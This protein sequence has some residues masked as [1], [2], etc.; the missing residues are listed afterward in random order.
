MSDGLDQVYVLGTSVQ[1]ERLKFRLSDVLKG[2]GVSALSTVFG[3]SFGF[4]QKV[5]R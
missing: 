2:V 5:G 4:R 1:R 3:F